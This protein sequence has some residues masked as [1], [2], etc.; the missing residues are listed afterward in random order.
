M[1]TRH[2]KAKIDDPRLTSI[3]D[4]RAAP[5]NPRRISAQA[6]AALAKSLG[7]FGDLSGIVWNARTGKL[8]SGHQRVKE[9]RGMGARYVEED[10]R[11]WLEHVKGDRRERFLVRV[12]DWPV[13]KERAANVVAN[14]PELAGEFTDGLDAMLDQI[15]ADIGQHD[16]S[17]LLLDQL[18]APEAPEA[19]ELKEWDA[20][21]LSLDGMFIFTAPIEYQAKIR[22][23]LEREF[24]GLMMR[25]EVVYG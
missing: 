3:D 7:D 11:G 5:D 10:G 9:L 16:F 22:A 2:P 17:A 25:E 19:A 4:L 24:P 13:E 14:S 12:V 1:A 15:V 8:V 21:E 6:A 23:V 18:R 20:S